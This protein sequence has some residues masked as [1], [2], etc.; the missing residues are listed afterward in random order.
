MNCF[1][2]KKPFMLFGPSILPI[3]ISISALIFVTN[4]KEVP[5]KHIK[6]VLRNIAQQLLLTANDSISGMLPGSK[7]NERAYRV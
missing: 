6:V 4:K 1:V 7:L 2:H 3:A 5:E